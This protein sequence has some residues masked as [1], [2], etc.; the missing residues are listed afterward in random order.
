MSKFIQIATGEYDYQ[1]SKQHNSVKYRGHCLY[2]LDE[3][4]QIWKWVVPNG[5]GMWKKWEELYEDKQW[6]DV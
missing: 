1:D 4:G 6:Q 2:A 3:E 5:Q